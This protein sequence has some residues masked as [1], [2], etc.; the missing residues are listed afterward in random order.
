MN[1]EKSKKSEK[2]SSNFLEPQPKGKVDQ[3]K[4]LLKSPKIRC[5]KKNL[6]H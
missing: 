5:T 4:R 1:A 6:R 3:G 2:P